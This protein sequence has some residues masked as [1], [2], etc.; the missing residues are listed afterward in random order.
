MQPTP[1]TEEPLTSRGEKLS[2]LR[3][4]A[5]IWAGWL[6]QEVIEADLEVQS[7][8]AGNGKGESHG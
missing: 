1:Q 8:D 7:Q 3:K 6:P 2:D 4:A 5:Q